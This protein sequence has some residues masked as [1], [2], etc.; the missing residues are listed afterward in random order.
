MGKGKSERKNE[1][2]KKNLI[3][4]NKTPTAAAM[5]TANQVS[6]VVGVVQSP[7]SR[8]ILLLLFLPFFSPKLTSS[9]SIPSFQLPIVV[10]VVVVIV[11]YNTAD[12]ARYGYRI[13]LS[14]LFFGRGAPEVFL[15]HTHQ[16]AR[17]APATM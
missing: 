12:C 8:F 6:D 4:S 14:P 15:S 17:Q 11:R 7:A 10:V 3:S 9:F 13:Y 2:K 1:E 16:A 5:G